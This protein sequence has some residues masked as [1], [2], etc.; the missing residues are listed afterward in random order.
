ML[1]QFLAPYF[2]IPQF[3]V[4]K[5]LKTTIILLVPFLKMIGVLYFWNHNSGDYCRSPWPLGLRRRSSAA[6]LLRLWVR[7]SQGGMDVCLL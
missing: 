7:I 5:I 6:R 4:M 2:V 1:F 3:V